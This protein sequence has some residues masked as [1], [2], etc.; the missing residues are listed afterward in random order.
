[1]RAFITAFIMV[2]MVPGSTAISAIAFN[3]GG[4]LNGS[5]V[6]G[7]VLAIALFALIRFVAERVTDPTTAQPVDVP[8]SPAA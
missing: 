5:Y 3:L 7:L 8:Y 1:M 6:P 2:S 4:G